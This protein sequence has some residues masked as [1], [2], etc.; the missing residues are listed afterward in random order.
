M[1][2]IIR[3]RQKMTKSEARERCKIDEAFVCKM[4]YQDY[5]ISTF[6]TN[7]ISERNKFHH[8]QQGGRDIHAGCHL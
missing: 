8:K 1:N 6:K 7:G 5:K 2:R 4:H 3:D